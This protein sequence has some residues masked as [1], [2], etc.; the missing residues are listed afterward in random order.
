MHYCIRDTYYDK[1]NP[2]MLPIQAFIIIL[3]SNRF[4]GQQKIGNSLTLQP[5]RLP[6]VQYSCWVVGGGHSSNYCPGSCVS[7]ELSQL[8]EATATVRCQ[9]GQLVRDS[10]SQAVNLLFNIISSQ[11]ALHILNEMLQLL[12]LI[13]LSNL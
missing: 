1:L 13:I 11:S 12:I 8:S 9:H 5:T 3:C 2:V 4:F 7:V 6:S 10:V